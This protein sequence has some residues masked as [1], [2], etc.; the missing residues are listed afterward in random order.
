MALLMQSIF[1]GFVYYLVA[2]FGVQI[3]SLEGHLTLM[4]PPNAVLLSALLI[5]SVK[6]WPYYMAAVFFAA[7]LS[8][9]PTFS[10]KAAWLFSLVNI[11]ECLLVAMVIRNWFSIN[12][13]MAWNDPQKVIVFLVMILFVATPLSALSAATVSVYVVGN[14][15]GFFNIWRLFWLSHGTGL[16]VLTPVFMS[17]FALY[18][19]KP[20]NRS[21][22]QRAEAVLFT[23][24]SLS[25]WI[26]VFYLAIQDV[27]FFVIAPILI[28]LPILWD[29]LQLDGE[30]KIIIASLWVLL[31]VIL[32]VFDLGPF[33][34]SD[35]Q[36][37]ALLTQ[38]FTIIFTS[39]IFLVSCYHTQSQQ[40]T[41]RLK[42]FQKAMESARE[43]I[44]ITE[45]DDDQKI[46]YSNK[47]F[48]QLSG[49]EKSE[50][51]GQN[52]RFLSV[53]H[54]DQEAITKIKQAITDQTA[55]ETVL[56]NTTKQGK[57][58]WNK[59]S[60]TP[61]KSP[62]G[63]V[64]HFSG[65]QLDVTEKVLLSNTLEDQVLARTE[66][67]SA[68][69]ERLRLAS[70]VSGLGI[71]EWDLITGVLVWDTNMHAIYETPEAVKESGLFYE[72]WEQSL[73]V[74]DLEFARATLNAAVEAHEEWA[75]EFR[76]QL[77]S[78]IIK[79]IQATATVTLNDDGEAV[80]VIGGNI[81]ISQQR[82]LEEKLIELAEQ[83]RNAS[84][85]KSEFLANMSH[86][87][88]TPMN[89]VLGMAELIKGT[90][91]NSRQQEY[92]GMIETSAK[93][94]LLILND[95]L[96]LSKIEA[97][98]LCLDPI[99]TYLDD[100]LGDIMKS[101]AV[102]AHKKQLDLHYYIHPK[103]P[104]YIEI[105]RLRFG[106]VLFNLVGN[107]VKFTH[108]GQVIVEVSCDNFNNDP[109]DSPIDLK[110]CVRDTGIGIAKHKQA[111]IFQPFQ[112]ADNSVT[113]QFGGTGLGLPI[114][115]NLVRLMGGDISLSSEV[116]TGT[117]INLSIPV[118]R[119]EQLESIAKV[120][121]QSSELD[122]SALRI[123]AVDDNE[124]NQRWLKDMAESWGSRIDIACSVSQGL[125]YIEAAEKN[126]DP[127]SILITDKNMPNQS[128]FD[129]VNAIKDKKLQRPAV[130]IM[131]SSSELET[132]IKTVS[133]LGI[134]E[135]ILKPVKQSEVFN[136][137][138]N[139]LYQKN[140]EQQGLTVINGNKAPEPLNIL[141]AED[142][143]VNQRIIN[144]ILVPRGHQVTIAENGV[145]AVTQAQNK[146]FDIILMDVQ[147]PEMD[148]F[149]ATQKIRALQQGQDKKSRIIGVTAHALKG[150]KELGLR[151]GMDGYL[152]KP[153]FAEQ[154]IR[155]VEQP[156]SDHEGH[157]SE[158]KVLTANVAFFDYEK[159]LM[160]TGNSQEL[161]LKL[162][163]MTLELLPGMLE[164]IEGRIA[165]KAETQLKLHLHKLTGMIA[166]L[167]SNDLV[168]QLKLLESNLDKGLSEQ[169]KRSWKIL[170]GNIAQFNDELLAFVGGD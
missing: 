165:A 157:Q 111:N 146:F 58:F 69:Q 98:Q 163:H 39:I 95:I 127:I 148:G 49:Y 137:I 44:V 6:H 162:S 45:A 170:S 35:I 14:E 68:S 118:G 65:I 81:D 47:A 48:Q 8:M 91:L 32:T 167:C 40:K 3:T 5:S 26:V 141:V 37:S 78:G 82:E 17:I 102:T 36:A 113:R 85:A 16:L 153:V 135:F 125:E 122:F 129:L 134:E 76:L 59:L 87:I 117:E 83:A 104:K 41:S 115:V 120:K 73:H 160:V 143:V 112:Q 96:D 21:A 159:A 38:K 131:L 18:V 150:D 126:N 123:L 133:N 105:D 145:L 142:N 7:I 97:G 114:V 109:N 106:Q 62:Q 25:L 92:V 30:Q 147:M 57:D 43:G 24:I 88:R 19:H 53:K 156:T 42:V 23:L 152:T 74:D 46:I 89:G 149:E 27:Q 121:S 103:V 138:Q 101:F 151:A 124:I 70:S 107:A 168:E 154:L 1:V 79:H 55:I 60:I 64:T 166:N 75:S 29:K 128:G 71:W 140:T 52:C 155:V 136:A 164:N 15:A 139:A 56:L 144:D 80:K 130:V 50:I 22:K 99:P 63:K 158:T 4:W 13:F 34:N 51:I 2:Y 169:N 61:I 77:P 84:T 20:P 94:L 93:S 161:L 31:S 116:G 33:V 11:L 90:E 119:C 28:L 72:F 100:S 66:E 132:D 108:E 86:E 110:V 10:F 54:R 12:S 9:I 67:L